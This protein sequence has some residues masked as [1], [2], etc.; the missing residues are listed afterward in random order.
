M[1]PGDERS[2]PMGS[3]TIYRGTF[4]RPRLADSA[5]VRLLI[6]GHSQALVYFNG[7]ICTLDSDR[8]GDEGVALLDIGS[9]RDG[10]NVIAVVAEK[11]QRPR[12]GFERE[13]P[14]VVKI[15]TPAHHW[16]RKLFNGLAQVIVR[17]T[18]ESGELKLDAAAPG[19]DKAS[20]SLATER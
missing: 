9:F 2:D 17:S 1:S 15:K 10:K 13:S 3:V 11:P 5:E 20:I 12:D 19:L 18:V 7:R 4:D 6:R 14:V 16:R 8:G